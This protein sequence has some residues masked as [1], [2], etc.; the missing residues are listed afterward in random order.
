MGGV[1]CSVLRGERGAYIDFGGNCRGG[2]LFCYYPCHDKSSGYD[3]NSG[4][5][6][7]SFAILSTS[8]GL[9]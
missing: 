4:L 5:F 3:D 8:G 9:K 1:I 2:D 7:D 6:C